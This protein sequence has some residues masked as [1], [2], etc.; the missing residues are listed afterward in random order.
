MHNQ[1]QQPSRADFWTALHQ[2][3]VAARIEL[4]AEDA[5]EALAKEKTVIDAD[6]VVLEAA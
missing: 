2:A 6:F 1:E 4:V 5:R 3:R